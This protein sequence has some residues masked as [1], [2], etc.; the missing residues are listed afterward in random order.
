MVLLSKV[1]WL[2][3]VLTSRTTTLAVGDSDSADVNTTHQIISCPTGYSSHHESLEVPLH[4][5]FEG[6]NIM[7]LSEPSPITYMS[8]QSARFRTLIEHIIQRYPRDTVHLVTCERNEE[9]DHPT[10]CYDNQVPIYYT[11]GF[12]LP[13]YK[14]LS[15]AVDWTARVWRLATKRRFDIIHVSSPGGLLVPAILASYL[16]GIPL[17]MSYHTH[18]PVYV[19]TYF[20]SP[21]NRIMEWMVWKLLQSLHYWSDLTVVTSPQIGAELSRH[22][23]QNVIWPKGVDTTQFH[24]NFQSIEMRKKMSGGK[25]DEFF[26]LVYV[27]RLAKEKRLVHLKSILDKLK[28]KQIPAHLCIVG[29][30]PEADDLIRHFDGTP[31]TFLGKLTGVSLSQ[32]FASG[33]VFVMPS[34]SETLGFVVMESL[35]SGVPVVASK[36]GGLID[37]IQEGST[38]FLVPPDDMDDFVNKIELLHRDNLLRERMSAQGR[39]VAETW[40]WEASMD[41]LRQSAYP[42][43][44]DRFSKRLS[45]RIWRRFSGLPCLWS[46]K[47]PESC[48]TRSRR[49]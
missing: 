14:A 33:D 47:G 30:G 8:G 42:E 7:V 2:L 26:L 31:T 12:R 17:M 34:D 13:Q 35:P 15:V 20:P 37:L 40:S 43:T 10:S 3:M 27:G 49:S 45:H 36:A 23:I 38:G 11:G 6:I 9:L 41:Y 28:A 29:D 25:E 18:L 21:W 5:L 46:Q 44:V 48:A 32:A 39:K 22:G 24:P 1:F 4:S 19:R 16:R